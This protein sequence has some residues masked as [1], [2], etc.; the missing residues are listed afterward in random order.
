MWILKS[1]FISLILVLAFLRPVYGASKVCLGVEAKT[2]SLFEPYTEYQVTIHSTANPEKEWELNLINPRDGIYA[3]ADG[4]KYRIDGSGK[5]RALDGTE[6]QLALK[7]PPEL[8]E[9]E[10]TA[11][12]PPTTTFQPGPRLEMSSGATEQ[13]ASLQMRRDLE[14]QYKAVM[15]AL[16]YLE[17]NPKHNSLNSHKYLHMTGPNGEAL[18]SAAGGNG[19]LRPYRILWYYGSD[20]KIIVHGIYP[21]STKG[22]F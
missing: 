13:L 12:A 19:A 11:V 8:I 6:Q 2:A 10:I 14:V 1:F 7:N 15:K 16:K 5:I 4:V 17:E 9:R 21:H 20:G 22:R 3:R 18:Y